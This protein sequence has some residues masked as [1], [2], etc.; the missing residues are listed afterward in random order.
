MGEGRYTQQI[1]EQR[2]RRVSSA[3][4]KTKREIRKLASSFKPPPEVSV[5]INGS[6]KFIDPKQFFGKAEG[7]AKPFLENCEMVISLINNFGRR[8]IQQEAALYLMEILP[9]FE[10]EKP[11]IEMV[12]TAKA[13]LSVNTGNISS[14]NS[15]ALNFLER[16]AHMDIECDADEITAMMKAFRSKPIMKSFKSFSEVGESTMKNAASQLLALGSG[17]RNPDIIPEIGETINAL[18]EKFGWF[19]TEGYR[20]LALEIAVN[21]SLSTE[22][23]ENLIHLFTTKTMSMEEDTTIYDFS[24][25]LK[26][27]LKGNESIEKLV[28]FCHEFVQ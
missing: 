15:A 17:Y 28:A 8:E 5:K 27:R 20:Q 19:A 3:P 4:P 25:E 21:E 7:E 22:D 14:G 26:A 23:K 2:K 24:Q 9:K 16:I 13:I 12:K 18:K 10:H 6:E 11:F 1:V